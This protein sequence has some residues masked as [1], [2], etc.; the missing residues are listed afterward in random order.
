MI[1]VAQNN[2]VRLTSNTNEKEKGHAEFCF[3]D[4]FVSIFLSFKLYYYILDKKHKELG[5]K[6]V[7]PTD[8]LGTGLVFNE[9]QKKAIQKALISSF[10]LIQG[11]PGS[12]CHKHNFI[13]VFISIQ[14]IKIYCLL[15]T[16]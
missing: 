15:Y 9:N 11:P 14:F 12:L 16:S 2:M 3:G 1:I 8:V 6:F 10:S 13:L 4:Q 7:P 5:A